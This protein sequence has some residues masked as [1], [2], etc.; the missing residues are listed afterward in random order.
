LQPDAIRLV[1]RFDYGA[2]G[3]R[4]SVTYTNYE[5]AA[6]G[7][8][9]GFQRWDHADYVAA[10]APLHTMTIDTVDVIT[11]TEATFSGT[12]FYDADPAYTWT[13]SG[14]IVDGVVAF[15]ILYTGTLPGYS[16]DAVDRHRP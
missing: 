1:R 4:G 6:P 7:A 2:T 3:A 8:E 13:V 5:Y 9:P 14:S 12:G 16:F 11:P 15:R 10:G